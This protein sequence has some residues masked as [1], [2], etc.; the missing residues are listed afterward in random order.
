MVSTR[1]VFISQL[2][3]NWRVHF[4]VGAL[5]W[6]A[7]QAC[8]WQ[9]AFVLLTGLS[10]RLFQRGQ[11]ASPRM[12][13]LGERDRQQTDRGTDTKKERKRSTQLEPYLLSRSDTTSGLQLKKK[14]KWK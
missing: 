8:S 5:T 7:N 9:E 10:S 2:D 3:W 6:Q 1:A 4:S 11:L 12:S 14:K 13:E